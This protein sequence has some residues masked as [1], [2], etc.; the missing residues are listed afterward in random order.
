MTIRVA[1]I[2]A[3]VMGADH[4]RIVATEMPGAELRWVCDA[5]PARARAVADTTGAR[6]VSADP[7]AAIA[8]ADVDAVLIAS[9]D[10]THAELTLACLQARK[11]VLCEKP[12][13][14][15]VAEC[16]R[17]VEAEN[18]LGKR[19]VQIGYMRRF[20]P[21]Y[22]EMRARTS[23][24]GGQR[25]DGATDRP[26]GAPIMMHNFHR[27]VS[28]PPHFTGAMAITNSAPHEFDI[29]RFVLGAEYTSVCAF[30]PQVAPPGPDAGS[31][32]TSIGP[33]FMVLR[34]DAGQL[35]N[36]E[37]NNNAG[38]GY[39]VRCELVCEH[40]SI[41][42]RAPAHTESNL[43]LGKTTDYAPDWRPRFA[44]A[45]RQQ[46]RAWL[47]S[48]ETGAAAGASAWDGHVA[49]LTAAAAVEALQTG[50]EVAIRNARRPALYRAIG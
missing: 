18:T 8:S 21:P 1:V 7:L 23:A 33:V 27:N 11:P 26:F 17:V 35:V 42:L 49:S 37:V 22:V 39:D 13:S 24:R 2:G 30:Q 47:R 5:D 14:Q 28:A 36:I 32:G 43:H 4:A 25:A 16:L 31:A 19:L 9:P 12:L 20:D 6:D 41:S 15:E 10:H 48:I 44:D 45:Y 50:R 46:A 38:Y 34:T 40:G 3:G 29:A